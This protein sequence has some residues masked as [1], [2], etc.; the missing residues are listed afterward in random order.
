MK[1]MDEQAYLTDRVDD[2]IN[3]LD[4][5]SGRNQK[6]Y[7]QLRVLIIVLSVLIPFGA[8]F[9]EEDA[10][11]FWLR[12]VVGAAGVIIAV[13]E[14]VISLYKYQDLWIKYRATA[15]H[16]QREKLLYLTKAEKYKDAKNPFPLFVERVE[17]IL[18]SEN[19]E[20]QEYIQKEEA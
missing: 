16:L 7:K 17:S 1:T 13:S 12:I 5:K 15:E 2:Q 14:G 4:R 11:L 20:W 6:R 18:Q 9:M 10:S 8:G 19:K 3:W